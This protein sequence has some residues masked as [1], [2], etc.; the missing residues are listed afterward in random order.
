MTTQ[1]HID[2]LTDNFGFNFEKSYD[3][4]YLQLEEIRRL[5][6]LSDSDGFFTRNSLVACHLGTMIMAVS[7]VNIAGGINL[8]HSKYM[9]ES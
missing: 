2:R 4:I 5:V 9:L 1:E 7:L 8:S 3:K 6:K